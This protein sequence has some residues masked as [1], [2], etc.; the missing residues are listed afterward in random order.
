MTNP[1]LFQILTCANQKE[2]L[3]VTKDMI[4]LV[5]CFHVK[6]NRAMILHRYDPASEVL[7]HRYDSV[8]EKC[9]YFIL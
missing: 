7:L 8:S 6:R 2:M 9:L 5:K 4:L 3:V 1:T